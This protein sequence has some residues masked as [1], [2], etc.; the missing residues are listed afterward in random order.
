[1]KSKNAPTDGNDGT[2]IASYCPRMMAC[3]KPSHVRGYPQF[4][5]GLRRSLTIGM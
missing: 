3:L 2:P 1:M 5:G 4:M